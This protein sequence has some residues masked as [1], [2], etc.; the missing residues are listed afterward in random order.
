MHHIGKLHPAYVGG[1][2]IYGLYYL[3]TLSTLQTLYTIHTIY[4]MWRTAGA[5]P[6]RAF[7]VCQRIPLAGCLP[8]TPCTPGGGCL[9]TH[10]A[11]R[12][13]L[14]QHTQCRH[15]KES[16]FSIT[17]SSMSI[18]FHVMI[19]MNVIPNKG[20]VFRIPLAICYS[21]GSVGGFRCCGTFQC[22]E[23]W[24]SVASPTWHL[25]FPIQIEGLE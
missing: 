21:T 24:L 22:D 19:E 10:P 12:G 25:P 15:L 6:Y 11:P 18:L 3:Q 5:G 1:W 20:F 8:C 17:R 23:L 13:I 16:S 7:R 4:T 14:Q 9:Q 2:G